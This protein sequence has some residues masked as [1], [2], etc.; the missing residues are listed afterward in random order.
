MM[1]VVRI[2]I[3]LIMRFLILALVILPIIWI[4]ITSLLKSR[5]IDPTEPL[6]ILTVIIVGFTGL[7]FESEMGLFEKIF[8]LIFYALIGGFFL[9]VMEETL[10]VPLWEDFLEWIKSKF[11]GIDKG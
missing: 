1:L 9:A 11:G 5:N 8:G 2:K 4:M 7:F 3:G 10:I 6:R